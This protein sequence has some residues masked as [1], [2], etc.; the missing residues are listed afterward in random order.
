[1]P[2]PYSHIDTLTTP[3]G[4][5][6]FSWEFR[7]DFHQKD[8]TLII[9][10]LIDGTLDDVRIGDEV[11]F[12]EREDGALRS[13][14]G[15]EH[16]IRMSCQDLRVTIFDNHN[17]ALYYWI[18]A[19]R[20]GLISPGCELIHIDEHSDLWHNEHTLDLDRSI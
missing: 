5:N 18:E 6:I 17:H 4:N 16:F 1:M 15:L 19:A 9:P 2:L 10:S 8:P 11:V 20:D 13:C 3:V 14:I 12:E 7:R